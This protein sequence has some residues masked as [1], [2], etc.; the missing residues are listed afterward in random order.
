MCLGQTLI[1]VCKLY[2]REDT[3]FIRGICAGRSHDSGQQVARY[4]L[5]IAGVEIDQV[6]QCKGSG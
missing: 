6:G 1:N 2:K 3:F 4:N 5:E